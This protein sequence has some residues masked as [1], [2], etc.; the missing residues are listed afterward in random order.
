MN[1]QF[2]FMQ[3]IN[4]TPDS[5]SDGGKY[6]SDV[7]LKKRIE[8]AISWDTPYLDI[9]AQSTAPMNAPIDE[10]DELDRFETYLLPVL[11]NKLIPSSTC[12]SIDTYR[13]LVFEKVYKW[14][15]EYL[16]HNQIIF[17]D[18]SGV[19]DQELIDLMKKYPAIL[20]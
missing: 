11:I 3:V 2:Q 10:S 13:P 5:F 14:I 9:G 8:E 16:P 19:L 18:V 15:K 4:I 20:D 1:S 6:N 7:G 17:N 12:L